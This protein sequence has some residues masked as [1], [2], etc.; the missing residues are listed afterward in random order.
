MA[1]ASAAVRMPPA[2]FTPI[3]SPTTLRIRA[4]SSTVAP[5]PA[6]PVDVLTKSAP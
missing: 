6:K 4:T 3:D 1:W 5:P 2:A